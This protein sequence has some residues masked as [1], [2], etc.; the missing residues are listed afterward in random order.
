M[1]QEDNEMLSL[2]AAIAKRREELGLS[3]RDLADKASVSNGTVSFIEQGITEE[4]KP[5]TLKKIATAL[6]MS[7]DDLYNMA[8]ITLARK[9]STKLDK[10]L[11]RL[12]DTLARMPENGWDEVLK[13]AEDKQAESESDIEKRRKKKSG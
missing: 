13:Y 6:G 3:Q 1:P 8:G 4:P 10:I 11:M 5:T 12:A 7:L 9:P 2:G